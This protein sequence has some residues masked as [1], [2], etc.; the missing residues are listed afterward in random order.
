MD[1]YRQMAGYFNK[2]KTFKSYADVL[3]ALSRDIDEKVTQASHK[4][5]LTN[6]AAEKYRKQFASDSV[7]IMTAARDKQVILSLAR[8]SD[9]GTMYLEC[10]EAVLKAYYERTTFGE[11]EYDILLLEDMIT[12]FYHNFSTDVDKMKKLAIKQYMLTYANFIEARIKA[13]KKTIQNSDL[14]LELQQVDDRMVA[15]RNALHAGISGVSS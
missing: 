7:S 10:M 3:T 15:L 8:D 14:M 11:V 1:T 4:N 2:G 12:T 13:E 6:E 5:N 9:P